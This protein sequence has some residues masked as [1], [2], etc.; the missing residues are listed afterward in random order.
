MRP[1]FSVPHAASGGERLHPE[2]MTFSPRKLGVDVAAL[3]I[4][5]GATHGATHDA[6][7]ARVRRLQQG[8]RRGFP[9]RS[10]GAASAE[11]CPRG[12]RARHGSCQSECKSVIVSIA[13]SLL[14]K[15]TSRGHTNTHHRQD[16]YTGFIPCRTSRKHTP[17]SYNSRPHTP[18]RCAS[19][20]PARAP[21]R[22]RL[23][24]NRRRRAAPTT[25]SARA[26]RRP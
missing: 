10:L 25:A 24:P 7:A 19:R 17:D 9:P 4:P 21:R 3:T 23:A 20:S 13:L 26:S 6:F 18:L 22:A 1:P 16:S 2:I 15:R 5:L 14:R 12:L 8:A 11:S